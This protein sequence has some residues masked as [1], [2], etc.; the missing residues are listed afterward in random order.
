MFK[1]IT[2]TDSSGEVYAIY[3]GIVYVTTSGNELVILNNEIYS[4]HNGKFELDYMS[5]SEFMILI[6][7]L[8]RK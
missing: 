4:Y 8:K 2:I 1:D 5:L 7:T 3:S 6:P